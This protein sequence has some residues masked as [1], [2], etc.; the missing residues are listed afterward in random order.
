MAK[1]VIFGVGEF[2]EVADYYLKHDSEHE[3]VAFTVNREYLDGEEA[4]GR[5]LV[6][7]EDLAES[8]PPAECS[9][10][11]AV[12]FSGVNSRRAAAYEMAKGAGYELITYVSSKATYYDTPIGDNCFVFED[13]TIQPFSSMGNNVVLWSGNHVGHHAE[14]GN[15]CFITSHV[16]ISG[17][18]KVHDYAFLGVNATLRD[19]IEI[20]ERCV[21]GAGALIMKSTEPSSVYTSPRAERYRLD[22]NQIQM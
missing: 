9:M 14:I 16:V 8:Y 13:N 3:V 20:G 21:V 2:A 18:V 10:F 17:G 12:G 15:H 11:V 6:A 4:F 22:S 1:V 19:H 7:F 5:P